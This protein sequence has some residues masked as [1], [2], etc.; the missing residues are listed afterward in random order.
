MERQTHETEEP[1]Y[2]P[3][4]AFVGM[5]PQREPHLLVNYSNLFA[6]R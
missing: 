4:E 1:Y 6:S 3:A 5:Q 2:F